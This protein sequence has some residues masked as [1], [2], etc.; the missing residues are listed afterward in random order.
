MRRMIVTAGCAAILGLVTLP[1]LA[2]AVM[3][4]EWKAL[5]EDLRTRAGVLG[6]Y[7]VRSLE[8][9]ATPRSAPGA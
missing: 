5:A 2:W 8:P 7:R 3:G 1:S 4:A 9:R 6:F